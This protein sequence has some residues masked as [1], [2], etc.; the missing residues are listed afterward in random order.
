MTSTMQY[1]V[2]YSRTLL[3]EIAYEG[4]QTTAVKIGCYAYLTAP[5][6]KRVTTRTY[7]LW[8]MLMPRH[9]AGTYPVR[10][11][12]YHYERGRWVSKGYTTARASDAGTSSTRALRRYKFPATGSW[13]VR[14]YHA[15]A[16]HV[17]TWTTYRSIAVR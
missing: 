1:R 2:V 5:T 16:G 11:Y 3:P 7:D 17:A 15:D 14:A 10:L 4:S 13:R 8:A 9:A 12:L 6:Y